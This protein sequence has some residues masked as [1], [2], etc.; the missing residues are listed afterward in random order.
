M[1]TLREIVVGIAEPLG[2]WDDEG[3]LNTLKFTFRTWRALLIRRDLD[4]NIYMPYEFIQTIKCLNLEWVDKADCCEVESGCNI[5]QS[6]IDIPKTVR[7]KI[8]AGI[9]YVGGIDGE[10]PYRF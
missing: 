8:G 6:T 7:L 3:F 5:L 10:S 1:A 9:T 2:K 4:R